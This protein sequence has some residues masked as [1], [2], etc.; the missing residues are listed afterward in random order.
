MAAKARNDAPPGTGK[1]EYSTGALNLPTDLRDLLRRVSLTRAMK[2]GVRPSV[3]AV[4]V[5][6]I[7]QHR[8]ELEAEAKG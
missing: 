5:Q 1:R 2:T 6:L 4:L 7:E 3:S 8:K